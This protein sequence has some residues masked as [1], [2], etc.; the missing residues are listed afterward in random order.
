M[1]DNITLTQKAYEHLHQGI[2][3]GTF[4]P[5]AVV[6]EASLAVQMGI[7]RT[8]VREAIRQL[9]T[10]GLVEQVPRY[11]T[12]IR[13]IDRR[14]IIELYEMREALESYA[15]CRAAERMS[16]PRLARLDALCGVLCEVGERARKLRLTE[17]D[18]P[19]LR[20]FLAADM[21][22][23][24]LIISAADNS[25]IMKVVKET[26][27]LSRIFRMRRQRHDL[28]IVEKAHGSHCRIVDA[29]RKHDSEAAR[30][31]MLE[32]IQASNRQTIEQ[33][34]RELLSHEKMQDI[35]FD[36]PA[37]LQ[38][39]LQLIEETEQGGDGEKKEQAG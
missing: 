13:S 16:E 7:S 28:E 3:S 23:H 4:A 22:F 38:E 14:E 33:Y 9:A 6:S 21:A 2:L 24:L 31:L 5:G 32:H 19:L 1:A 26:R 37:D 39:E 12:I 15:A 25:R 11:G 17:L 18:E 8:P 30:L 27:T 35:H 29:L 34:D 20:Q 10:E 36:L